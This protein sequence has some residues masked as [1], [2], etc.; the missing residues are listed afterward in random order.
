MATGVAYVDG[1][2]VTWRSAAA[3]HDTARGSLDVRMGRGVAYG[4]RPSHNRA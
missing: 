2:H 3:R 4:G 1:R